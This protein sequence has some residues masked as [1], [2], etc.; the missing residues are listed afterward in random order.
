MVAPTAGRLRET[1]E[2]EPERE[3]VSDIPSQGCT[4]L[5]KRPSRLD[6]ALEPSKLTEG[7]R[8]APKITDLARN[9]RT[10]VQ[11]RPC[12]HRVSAM[13]LGHTLLTQRAPD[14][15]EIVDR[16]A[17]SNALPGI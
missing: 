3:T 15:M 10:L 13:H 2:R 4:R 16:A 6:I 14:A 17:N 1:R 9:A 12:S 7:D 11:C 5:D 8:K